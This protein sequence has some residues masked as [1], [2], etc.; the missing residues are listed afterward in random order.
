MRYQIMVLLALFAFA[1]PAMAGPKTPPC[2]A[3]EYRQFDFWQGSWDVYT[4]D[5]RKAGH[6]DITVEYGGC[7]LHER[8]TTPGKYRGE[9]LNT[10]DSA[11]KIWHQT[12]VDNAG[13]L[14]QLDG[15]WDGDAMRLIGSTQSTAGE[16]TQERISWSKNPDGSVR[17][18]W[19]Q[20]VDG[21]EWKT[22]FDGEYRPVI[23][24][25]D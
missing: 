7:V 4:P 25:P 2:S 10:Y 23:D 15:A 16:V 6:N 13:T 8:Y 12:W 1:A 19:E 17:Q 5:G 18:L 22:V 3:P 11:R 20:S 14:L 21:K 9:S 24:K